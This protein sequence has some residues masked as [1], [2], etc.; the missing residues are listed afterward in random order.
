M[1]DI[2][3][4][5]ARGSSGGWRKTGI[6]R[7]LETHIGELL[8]PRKDKTSSIFATTH[9]AHLSLTCCSPRIHPG[10]TAPPP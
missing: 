8:P 4:G 10:F 9:T 5:G 7:T 1:E 6:A 2:A 3:A